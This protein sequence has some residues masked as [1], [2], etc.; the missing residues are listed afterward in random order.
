MLSACSNKSLSMLINN[1]Q[2]YSQI[3]MLAILDALREI[4][5][6]KG[7]TDCNTEYF[8]DLMEN[9]MNAKEIRPRS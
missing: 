8:F 5:K 7:E 6:K 1:F 2:T 3:Q 4:L 9:I